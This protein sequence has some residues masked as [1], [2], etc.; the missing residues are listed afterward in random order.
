MLKG[1][2]FAST[3]I[4]S[5]SCR[6]L[7][8]TFF[9]L[10]IYALPFSSSSSVSVCLVKQIF[11]LSFLPLLLYPTR[12][13]HTQLHSVSNIMKLSAS[14]RTKN[15]QHKCMIFSW[16]LITTLSPSLEDYT[17]VAQYSNRCTSHAYV[18]KVSSSLLHTQI[19]SCVCNGY[20]H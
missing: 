1:M 3:T 10:L 5:I 20:I 9:L 8:F 18:Q 11:H 19:A 7:R 12:T 17:H 6:R 13:Y 2:L 15:Q 4:T 16:H 14:V